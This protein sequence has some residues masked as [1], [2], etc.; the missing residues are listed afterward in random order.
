MLNRTVCVTLLILLCSLTGLAQK[1]GRSGEGTV[2]RSQPLVEAGDKLADERRWPEAIES[3]NLA[4][5][6]DPKNAE[7]YIRLGDAQM[8]AGNWSAALSA[9]KLAVS[10]APGNAD[11]QYALGDAYN[12]MG[13]HGDAFAPLVRAI[14]IDP[15]FAEAHYGIGYAYLR[16][17][18]FEKSLPYLRGAIRLQPDYPEAH[19]SLALAYL[20]LENTNGLEEERRKLAALDPDLS[21]KL[22]KEIRTFDKS[23][24]SAATQ[25]ADLARK[26]ATSLQAAPTPAP[27][28]APSR[29]TVSSPPKKK[30]R[31]ARAAQAV[32]K[33]AFELT[34]WETIK[35]STDPE[36]FKAYLEK[37]PQGRF[38]D[39]AHQRASLLAPGCSGELSGEWETNL[40]RMTITK[41]DGKVVSG[42]YAKN[43]GTFKGEMVT[44]KFIL[45]GQWKDDSGAGEI[46]L[47]LKSD[48]K[49][50]V[51][52]LYGEAPRIINGQC[53]G[54]A[55]SRP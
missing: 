7:S 29:A 54:N 11:T 20:N 23:A 2:S 19:Y 9:Y 3:Y 30:T 18:Q 55:G 42:A 47:Q 22:E 40:G 43:N 34:F 8:G 37:Y 39:L 28:P 26:Q 16:G 14:Q 1:S 38:A 27:I 46:T 51:G 13:Q 50:L 48:R 52:T 12:T 35:D 25:A 31:T 10:V 45:S 49:S 44:D 32:D 15:G 24:S 53:A 4:I 33:A 41:G 36:D 21:N 17:S 5:R 6:L